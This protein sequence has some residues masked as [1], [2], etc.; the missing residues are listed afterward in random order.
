[1][2]GP[3][4]SLWDN[5]LRTWG[6]ALGAGG[7]SLFGLTVARRV[8]LGRMEALA[9]EAEALWLDLLLA[10]LR[11]TSLVSLLAVALWLALK[12]L[13]TT[14]AVD[15][16]LKVGLILAVLFQGALW[17]SAAITFILKDA[18]RRRQ[19]QDAG[20]VTALSA[21]GLVAKLVLWVL[22]LLL[23]LS[24]LGVNITGLLAGLGVGGIAVALAVQNILGDLFASLSIVLDKPFSVGDLITVGNCVGTVEHIG[25]KTTRVHSLSGEQIIFSNSDLLK[26]R[27]RNHKRMGERRV[28]FCIGVSRR[29]PHAQL[30]GLSGLLREII[31]AQKGVRFD[32]AHFRDMTG[33][34]LVF[35]MV[36]FL[37]DPGYNVFMDSQEA[38]NLEIVRRFEAQAILLEGVTPQLTP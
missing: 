19:A 35:E 3:G 14:P 20:S 30:A 27:I 17:V 2:I 16:I 15:H 4:T 6:L 1:M 5:S 21:M 7:L 37:A 26:S 23:A 13:A 22:V 12:T 9:K 10:V 29:T 31:E 24:N 8:G 28:L 38:I 36:Y 25:M 18:I 33:L 11:S 32:R 34:S